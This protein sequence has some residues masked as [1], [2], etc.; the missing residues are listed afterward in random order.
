MKSG[1]KCFTKIRRWAATVGATIEENKYFDKIVIS[2]NGKK[3]LAEQRES[4]SRL[5]IA[6]GRGLKWEGNPAGF[7]FTVVGEK[8]YG[9]YA[10]ESTQTRA[11]EEMEGN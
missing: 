11:I 7:F 5:T 6:R 3:Y 2:Y 8:G 9:D 1:K 10:F 4:T